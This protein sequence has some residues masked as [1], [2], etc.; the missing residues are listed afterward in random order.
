MRETTPAAMPP[1]FDRWC[2][3]FDDLLRTKAQKREFRNY[4][5][6]LLGES[7]RKNIYQMASDSVGV[8]Y[9]KLH[10]FLTEATW[11]ADKINQR[12]LEVMNK[13][14]QTRISRGFSLIVD[15][16][17]H[18]KSGNFTAGV[19]R[20]YIGEIGKTDNGNVVV[21]THL[22]DGKKSLP[23][24]IELYQHAN[25]LPEG[26]KDRNFQKK[27]EL[28]LKLIDRS[29]EREYRPGI[30]LIDS[31]YGN[32]TNFLKELEKRKLN[33]LGGLAKNRK[34]KVVN[35]KELTEEIRLDTL[36]ESLPEGTYTQTTINLEKSRT[37]WV[38]VMEVEISR[39]EGI[40]KIAI[41]MN[42]PNF[43]DAEDID[44]FITNV[45][46]SIV[47]AQWVV[48]TYS[49]RNWVEVFYREAKGWLGLKEYQARGIKSLKRHFILVFCAYS[50]IL[51]HKLTGGLRRRW[52]NKPL[53]TFP[54]ALEAFRTAMSY[55]FVQWLNHNLDVF[56]AYKASLGFI[57]A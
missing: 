37:V 48:E 46:P 40:R 49:Q 21:T 14:N 11:S 47:N 57:W 3:K 16:S 23:L 32:N 26:K 18:R 12:R 39:L 56:V 29:M 22:Y 28:A 6:G 9:H 33:Y 30:V 27:P 25:S 36:A 7:E 5:G 2:K 31:G 4:L 38:A 42:A 20:Q 52:A 10:H 51:W 13:C 54:E 55:R 45:E 41:V 19:G 15:D 50:F 1:C 35:S 53:N 24:D 34:V 17:G 8:T 43:K 44:Y